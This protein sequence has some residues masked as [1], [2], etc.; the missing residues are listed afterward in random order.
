MDNLIKIL[1]N[2]SIAGEDEL[3]EL[4]YTDRYNTELSEA[5]D[6]LRRT[7]YGRDVFIRGLIEI[8]SYC[9][10]NCLYCGIRYGN[11]NAQRYR[12]SEE[13]I[14]SCCR[15]GYGLGL[16]TF[17]LQG[18]EDSH[19]T[20]YIICRLVSRIKNMFPDCAV[21]LSLGEKSR[22]SYRAF[23]ENGA[24]RYLLRHE[25]ADETHYSKLHPGEMSLTAR[26]KCLWDLKELGYQ[27]GSGFMVGSPYQTKECIAADLKFLQELQPEMIGIGPFIHHRDTP[28]AGFP[29]GTA[30]L[31]VKLISVLR[32]L[33]PK[34]LIPATTSLG[35]VSPDGREQGLRAGANVVMPNLSP[36]SVRKKYSLYENKICTG[37]ESAECLSCLRRRIE[38]AGYVMSL[39]R[40]DHINNINKI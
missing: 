30:E 9:R 18:G 37:E 33:F 17:V 27:V 8:S 38:S 6:L 11:R 34:A 10:N 12:L 15:I 2:G 22:E 35:T 14:I 19:F 24:D 32:L 28:F 26:K 3:R 36:V 31:T 1:L 7:Y 21:T 39:S 4:I 25:T 29:D 40:G 5:A 20:D 13:E 23:R 16:R